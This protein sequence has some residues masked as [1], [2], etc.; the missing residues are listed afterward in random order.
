MAKRRRD[1]TDGPAP[2]AAKGGAAKV[3][4]SVQ[5]QPAL[6]Q[7][8]PNG[9]EERVKRVRLDCEYFDQMLALIPAKHYLPRP[10]GEE[11]PHWATRKFGKHTKSGHV[12][13]T[14][15]PKALSKRERKEFKR[16]KLD[17][18]KVESIGDLQRKRKADEAQ[19]DDNDDADNG[20]MSQDNG[21]KRTASASPAATNDIVFEGAFSPFCR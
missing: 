2:A 5:K 19:A 11:D 13:S 21:N 6:P 3:N 18:A 1:D 15:G 4:A 17:P 7:Q 20:K 8:E 14:T 9:D 10:E 16:V 12:P